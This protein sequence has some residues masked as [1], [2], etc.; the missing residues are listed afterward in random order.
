MTTDGR[1]WTERGIRRSYLLVRMG[2]CVKHD[3]INIIT[4][5]IREVTVW[6]EGSESREQ[7]E[8]ILVDPS[9]PWSTGCRGGDGG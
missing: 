3:H 2:N 5:R 8:V 4:T 6:R 1:D 7:T 9:S